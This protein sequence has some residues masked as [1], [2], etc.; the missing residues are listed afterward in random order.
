MKH[1]CPNHIEEWLEHCILLYG[2]ME[3]IGNRYFHYLVVLTTYFN[4]LED[5]ITYNNTSGNYS[6]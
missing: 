5:I 3:P 6:D 1:R 2:Y 4:N